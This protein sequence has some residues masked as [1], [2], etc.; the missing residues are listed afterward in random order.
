MQEY[1]GMIDNEDK[2]IFEGDRYEIVMD[3]VKKLYTVKWYE[4][5]MYFT[6]H[7]E[8]FPI[9]EILDMELPMTRLN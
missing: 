7:G 4:G 1:S 2:Q 3:G 5:G 9:G 6:A 8:Y